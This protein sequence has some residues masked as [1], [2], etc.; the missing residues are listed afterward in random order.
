MF[1]KKR[2]ERRKRKKSEGTYSF[3]DAVGDVLIWVPE[4]IILPF[5]ILWYLIRGIVSIFDIT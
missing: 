1:V 5:R 3:W 4:L 2:K